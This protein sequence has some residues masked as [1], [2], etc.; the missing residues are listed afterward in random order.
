MC[1]CKCG[2]APL[3]LG[4]K[5]FIPVGGSG[6]EV[7]VLGSSVDVGPPTKHVHGAKYR[8]CIF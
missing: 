3:S 8:A 1:L 4:G 7:S 2:G 6:T 5:V